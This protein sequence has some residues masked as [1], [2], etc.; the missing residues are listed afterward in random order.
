M[1]VEQRSDARYQVCF[2]AEVSDGA[3]ARAVQVANLSRR[4]CRFLCG[5]GELADG[6]RIDLMVSRVGAVGA[7]VIWRRG[8]W[9]GVVFDEPLRDAVL[10]H[11]RLFVSHE[12]A[13]YTEDQLTRT[14]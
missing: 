6:A 4:G 14:G 2:D 7:H 9:F 1:S 5:A 8:D 12:P 13:L 10:D 3:A 11:L